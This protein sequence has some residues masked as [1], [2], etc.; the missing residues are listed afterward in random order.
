[1]RDVAGEHAGGEPVDRVVGDRDRL[2]EI[3]ERQDGL[4]RAED[5]L[6]R[7]PHGVV[8]AG[9]HRRHEEMSGQVRPVAADEHG[10]A[11]LPARLDRREHLGQLLLRRDRAEVE[12]VEA[13]TDRQVADRGRQPLRVLVDDAAVHDQPRGGE[14]R[15]A[16]VTHDG[17]RPG[18]HGRGRD[19]RRAG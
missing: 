8:D 9:E 10:R 11:L 15:L 13:G 17:H 4:D 12:I 16:R 18:L 19:P 6:A 2:V 3:V 14:A 5:L 7:H 1:M